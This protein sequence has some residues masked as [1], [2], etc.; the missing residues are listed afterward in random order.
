MWTALNVSLCRDERD[1]RQRST[2]PLPADEVTPT[3]NS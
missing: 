3:G 1:A 2:Y